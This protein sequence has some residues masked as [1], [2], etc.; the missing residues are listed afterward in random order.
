MRL[1]PFVQSYDEHKSVYSATSPPRRAAG[2]R[3]CPSAFSLTF[4]LYR[5]PEKNTTRYRTV[6]RI[7]DTSQR[8]EHVRS[9]RARAAGA[10]P[11][12]STCAVSIATAM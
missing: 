3:T 1:Y 11:A 4:P 8:G 9:R 10:P 5:Y 2:E 6:G 7:S 12:P